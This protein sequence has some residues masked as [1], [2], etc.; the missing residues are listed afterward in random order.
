MEP[1]H[2]YPAHPDSHLF[3]ISGGEAERGV[4]YCGNAHWTRFRR[5][6]NLLG[7]QSSLALANQH[8]W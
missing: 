2:A 5:R 7:A 3:T 1:V 6:R 8:S 4:F